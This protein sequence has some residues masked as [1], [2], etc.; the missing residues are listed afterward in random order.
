MINHL[1]GL[2]YITFYLFL[3]SHPTIKNYLFK[4][5]IKNNL[6]SIF[7]QSSNLNQT[8]YFYHKKY[9]KLSNNWWLISFVISRKPTLLIFKSLIQIFNVWLLFLYLWNNYLLRRYSYFDLTNFKNIKFVFCFK[10]IIYLLSL[11]MI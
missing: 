1:N 6:I 3:L 9:H 11:L 4:I 7:I 8:S 5:W 2:N 10:L